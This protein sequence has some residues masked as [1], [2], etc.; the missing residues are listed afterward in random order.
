MRPRK[1]ND[2][3]VRRLRAAWKPQPKVRDLAK[4]YGIS[5][6]ALRKLLLG[7]TYKDVRP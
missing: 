5:R 7:H 1:L 3:Q 4:Q 6:Q 2:E